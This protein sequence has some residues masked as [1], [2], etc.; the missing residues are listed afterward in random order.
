MWSPSG[1]VATTFLTSLLL[2][3]PA[4]SLGPVPRELD[5]LGIFRDPDPLEAN[6]EAPSTINSALHP[7][8]PWDT[9][10]SW[11]KRSL[12]DLTL[13]DPTESEEFLWGGARSTFS[14]FIIVFQLHETLT[15]DL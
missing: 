5:S 2:F 15:K 8:P 1:L 7:L 4:A 3:Q 6:G 9:E 10:G 12:G 14:D 11:T 13:L